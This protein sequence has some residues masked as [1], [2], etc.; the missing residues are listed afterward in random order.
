MATTLSNATVEL[1]KQFGDYWA[2][3]T[4]TIGA[5]G[6]TTLID[7]ALI[8]KNNDWIDADN[9]EMY[10]RITSLTCD[11]QERRISSLSN[12]LGTLTVLAHTAQI[13]SGTTYEIHRL[14]TASDK[15]I[16]LI[17]ACRDL[18][19]YL[20]KKIKVESRVAG[21]WL[22]NGDVLT[23]TSSSY[24]DGWRVSAVTA[25]AYT[26]APYYK[27]TKS[28]RL[29]T[30]AGYLYTDMTLVPELAGLAGKTVTFTTQGWSDT[31][32][33]LR[34]AIYDG[35]DTTYSSYHDGSDT[36][37]EDDEPLTVTATIPDNPVDIEFRVYHAVAAATSYVSD[38]RVTTPAS[39]KVYIGDL[40]IYQNFPHRVSVEMSDYT[41]SEAEWIPL[42]D[43]DI[44]KDGY[45]LL[46]EDYSDLRLRLEG[47]GA[48]DFL[49]SGV[50]SNDW[51][52]TI[53][54][55]QPQLDVLIA[56]ACVNL[57]A[58]KMMPQ[59]TTDTNSQWNNAYSF[60]KNELAELKGKFSMAS[61]SAT[62]RWT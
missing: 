1:S 31:A 21:N 56:Q 18:F 44:D 11:G 52:A 12:T 20:Y 47:M 29:N 58:L 39:P 60:W 43:Y 42:H 32:S 3:T 25:T 33:T 35:T 48:I 4:T 8:A 26:T 16:A 15:R 37:T 6:G 30:A 49:A 55:D 23:W 14:F 19:P 51:A 24:P 62:T 17:R 41:Q 36:W 5:A 9:A 57:C 7:S 46:G 53:D 61:L 28:C 10:D 38:L 50:S 59:F 13:A 27:G 22:K 40:G 34:L 45:L 2:G 54:I